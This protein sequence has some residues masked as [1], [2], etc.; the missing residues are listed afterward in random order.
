MELTLPRDKAEA[1][2]SALENEIQSLK[3]DVECCSCPEE[4]ADWAM[5]VD[6]VAAIHGTLFAAAQTPG[7]YVSMGLNREAYMLLTDALMAQEFSLAA[8]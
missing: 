7:A 4:R 5:L 8:A 2:L 1:V 3:G 6:C